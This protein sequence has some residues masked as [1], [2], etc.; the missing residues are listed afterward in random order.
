MRHDDIA[1]QRRKEFTCYI[2]AAVL[3]TIFMVII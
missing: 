1:K 3:I 2:V